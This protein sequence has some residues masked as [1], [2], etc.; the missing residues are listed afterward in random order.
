MQGRDSIRVPALRFDPAWD[1][2]HAAHEAVAASRDEFDFRSRRPASR[3]GS[4][5][6]GS[7]GLDDGSH[8]SDPSLRY[9]DAEGLVQQVSLATVQKF[10]PLEGIKARCFVPCPGGRRLAVR[11]KMTCLLS[12]LLI[13]LLITILLVNAMT[14]KLRPTRNYY[15]AIEEVGVT[16]PPLPP[17][18]LPHRVGPHPPA[19]HPLSPTHPLTTSLPAHLPP[20]PHPTTRRRPDAPP[21]A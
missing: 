15:L 12:F 18:P 4:S 11:E 13:M 5:S 7:R 16:P 3:P 8:L 6:A 20:T 19:S 9:I 10:A 14:E 1:P 21:P 17:A 2:E